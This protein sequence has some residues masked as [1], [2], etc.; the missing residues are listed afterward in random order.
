[1]NFGVFSLLKEERTD[2]E[3][4]RRRGLAGI[5]S[6][7]SSRAFA[8]SLATNTPGLVLRSC[9]V[10]VGQSSELG[11]EHMH[12]GDSLPNHGRLRPGAALRKRSAPRLLKAVASFVMCYGPG[13]TGRLQDQYAYI[14]KVEVDR[15]RPG[16]PP[17]PFHTLRTGNLGK[18]R[19]EI[20]PM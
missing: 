16:N 18:L 4:R 8:I 20:T 13:L 12:S 5:C 9:L 10:L 1:M 2:T 15:Y 19:P 7:I 11:F 6:R 14:N 17:L 3:K